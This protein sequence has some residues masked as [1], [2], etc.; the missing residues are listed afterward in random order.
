MKPSNAISP[1]SPRFQEAEFSLLLA[2]ALLFPDKFSHVYFLGFSCLLTALI[3][4]R[5]FA[6]R[7]VALGGFSLL[8]LLL[9]GTFVLGAFFSP[10]P[11]KSIL[12]VADF[13]LVSLWS[14]LVYLEHVDVERWLRIAAAVISLSSLGVLVAFAVQGGQAGGRLFFANP[15]PQ[16]IA[17][18]LAAIVFLQRILDRARPA[19]AALL[20]MNSGAVVV[21]ASKAAALGL[22]VVATAMI[23][24]Q[25]RRWLPVLAAVL[26]LLAA[27][28]NPLRRMV[29]HS[30]RH[31]P[32]VLD[33]LDI[34]SMSARM[35]RAHPWTGVGPGL[36]AEAAPRFNFPQEKAPARFGKIPESPHSDYW[37]LIAENGLPGLL[38]VLALLFAAV[39]RLLSGPAGLAEC[40]LAFLLAQMLLFNFVF[41]FFFLLFFLLLLRPFFPFGRRF[42][43]MRPGLRALVLGVTAFSLLV[44]YLL[45]FLAQRCLDRAASERNIATRFD[46]LR[47]GRLL[48]PLDA[49]PPL[50]QAALLRSFAAASPAGE[51][52]PGSVEEAW[53]DAMAQARL[54]QRLNGNSIEALVLQAELLLDLQRRG[55]GYPALCEEI[56]A[57]L[58]LAEGLAPFNPFLKMRRAAVLLEFGRGRE[59]GQAAAEALKLEPDF[60][61]AIVFLHE[62]RGLPAEDPALTA[63]L[64]AIREK[65][66]RLNARPGSYLSRLHRLPGDRPEAGD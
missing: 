32:Y 37:Q 22:A 55:M 15:I 64:A 4:V 42:A 62:L 3:M 54:A 5:V 24:R 14:L 33:R 58:R 52:R 25:R 12:F 8:L 38:L 31:D 29:L 34:W 46:L 47:R 9:N 17:S 61:E 20:A 21:S 45:P 56:L 28:P 44:L 65:A 48:S 13:F 26:L 49:R 63:R 11:Y 6:V 51:P 41:H 23:L 2:W 30:L 43:A 19:D 18:A 35:Y 10:H 39:R 7:N 53:S 16:G 36:F 50:A 1:R 66:R 40:L 27:V 60:A 57:P 59:A